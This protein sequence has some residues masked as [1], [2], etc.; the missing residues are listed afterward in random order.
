MKKLI[1]SVI[2]FGLIV[3]AGQGVFAQ[4]ENELRSLIAT[5]NKEMI[6]LVV[7]GRYEALGK[8]YDQDAVSLPNYRQMEKGYKLILNNNNGRKAGGYQ[9]IEGQKTTIE[10]FATKE[11]LVDI[12][13]YTLT[14]T[15]PGLQQPKIDSGKYMNVWR[16][17]S[18]GN[19]RIVAETWNADKS[20][21]APAPVKSQTPPKT[22]GGPK[23]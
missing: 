6:D 15:F 11:M 22:D 16:L 8:Y 17:D 18:E 4:S 13:A 12:G 20:P 3:I 14:V 7:A 2:E 1:F 23:Q 5:K 9:V 10:F 19:W 21:N